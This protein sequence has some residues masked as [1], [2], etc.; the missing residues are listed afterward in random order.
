MIKHAHELSI[1]IGVILFVYTLAGCA[2]FRSTQGDEYIIRIGDRVVT[3]SEFNRA[4]EIAK[5]AYP[6]N[7]IQDSDAVRNAKSRLLNQ[8]SEEMIIQ[9][10]A[11]ETGIIISDEELEKAVSNIKEDYPEDAFEQVILEY[12]VSYDTWKNRIK[13]RLLIEKVIAQELGEQ[14]V[15]SADDISKYYEEHGM[16]IEPTSNENEPSEKIDTTI[17]KHLR[18]EKVEEAYRPWIL[19]LQ[20]KYIIE[21]NTAEWK[22]IMGS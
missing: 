16:D 12:A 3:V 15:I 4:F 10:R 9:E 13:T 17:V 18:R 11:L 5:A 8:M 21:I 14:I 7:E 19:D 1:L 22:K 2:D 20:K 6:H